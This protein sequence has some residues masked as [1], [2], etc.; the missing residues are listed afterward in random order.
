MGKDINEYNNLKNFFQKI[1]RKN[2]KFF[3]F[4]RS[5]RRLQQLDEITSDKPFK[6]RFEEYSKILNSDYKKRR[7]FKYFAESPLSTP[8]SYLFALLYFGCTSGL[9]V[10]TILVL[11][12]YFFFPNYKIYIISGVLALPLL[13]FVVLAIFKI[14]ILI[15]NIIIRKKFPYAFEALNINDFSVK[16]IADLDISIQS[17]FISASKI[18]DSNKEIND[19]ILDTKS[20]YTDDLSFISFLKDIKKDKL[21]IIFNSLNKLPSDSYFEKKARTHNIIGIKNATI[22]KGSNYFLKPINEYRSKS[23]SII[24]QISFALLALL[25]SAIGIRYITRFN[26]KAYYYRQNYIK[27]KADSIYNV[28]MFEHNKY[29]NKI[30]NSI[31]VNIKTQRTDNYRLG[32]DLS[33]YYRLNGKRVSNGEW[34]KYDGNEIY[35]FEVTIIENDETFNDF[36]STINRFKLTKE[37]IKENKFYEIHTTV[38][39]NNKRSNLGFS[40][41]VTTFSLSFPDEENCPPIPY[42]EVIELNISEELSQWDIFKYTYKHY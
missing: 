39:E 31:I 4:K 26:I 25:L 5:K 38:H 28:Q 6:T 7:I 29:A 19:K 23:N 22:N 9:G 14:P 20:N 16:T 1:G 17:L 24:L 3:C 32:D 42:R 11:I 12:I 34:I 10:L 8:F 36:K 13:F 18:L 15:R 27:H 30:K 37:D 2:F 35:N 40:K 33:Y 41:F 21:S